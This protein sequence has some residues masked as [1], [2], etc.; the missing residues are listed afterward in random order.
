M[1]VNFFLY[2]YLLF[3]S[4]IKSIDATHETSYGKFVND[5]PHANANA[6]MKRKIVNNNIRLC[7]FATEKIQSGTE[8]R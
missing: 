3:C 7:L 4:F 8:I 1:F 5:S 2:I 6:I